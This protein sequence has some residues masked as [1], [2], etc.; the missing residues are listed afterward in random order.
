YEI[1][2]TPLQMTMAYGALANGGVLM[3]PRLIREVRARGG[4]VEREVRPRAIRRVVPE[5][6]A[7]SVAG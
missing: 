4:R 7:R 5:D 6:V 1:G 3:E 2:V